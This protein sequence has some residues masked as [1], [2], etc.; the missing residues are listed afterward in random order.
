VSIIDW[1]RS[2][3]RIAK[4]CVLLTPLAR[5]PYGWAQVWVTGFTLPVRRALAGRSRPARLRLGYEGRPITWHLTDLSEF[6]ALEGVLGERHYDVLP[7]D[8][9]PRVVL[10]FGSHIGASIY[11]FWYAF[12]HARIVGVEADPSTFVRLRR[13]VEGLDRVDV[14]HAAATK[15]DG[16]VTFY[17]DPQASWT[18]S[19]N[20]HGSSCGRRIPARGLESLMRELGV[21]RV[22][23]LK[24][25]IEGAEFE[26]LRAVPGLSSR[27]RVII[28]ELHDQCADASFTVDD[29]VALLADY[30]VWIENDPLKERIFRAT[31]KV[32][33]DGR[34]SDTHGRSVREPSM[35]GYG[36]EDERS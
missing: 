4:A 9:D 6:Y 26:V 34:G 24:L 12:P 2:G 1:L 17:P 28:G 11:Y 16:L 33:E 13:H 31:R 18:S 30:D 20:Q 5:S 8:L 35:K 21:A 32:A 14:I 10:D 29:F 25:D 22:D 36:E 27:V 23:V 3:K 19:L 15:E 7:S